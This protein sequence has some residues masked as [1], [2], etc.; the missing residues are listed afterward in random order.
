VVTS[1]KLEEREFEQKTKSFG[2]ARTGIEE[3]KSK[4]RKI[5]MY[6]FFSNP[7]RLENPKMEPTEKTKNLFNRMPYPYQ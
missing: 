5:M 1:R 3:N 2:Q 7:L 4:R 6:I